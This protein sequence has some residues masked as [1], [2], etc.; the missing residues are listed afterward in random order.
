[1][2]DSKLAVQVRS[3]VN[4]LPSFPLPRPCRV[5]LPVSTLGRMLAMVSYITIMF[6][7]LILVDAPILSQHFLDDVA[8]RAAW[9]TLTQIPLVYL[10]ASKRGPISFFAGI[11]YERIN[12]IH[13]L[14]GPGLLLSATLHMG[15]MKSSISTS[16]ILQSQD[17]NMSVVRYGI[18]AYGVLVWISVT[19]ILPLRNWSY[20]IFYLNHWISTLGFLTIIFQHVPS[21]ACPPIYL[22][23]GIVML[24]KSKGAYDCIRNNFSVRPVNRR[25]SH[26]RRIPS[27][28]MLVTGYPIELTAPSPFILGF[29]TQTKDITTILRISNIPFSWRPGQHIRL[30]IPA[31]GPFEVHSFTPANCSALLPPPLPPRKDIEQHG[32]STHLLAPSASVQ[33]SEMLLM[34]RAYSGLTRRLANHHAD[35]LMRPC[36][37]ATE[38]IPA[39]PL[40]AYIDGPYGSVPRW[41]EYENLVLVATSTG[42]SFI[43]SIM[44]HLEQLCFTGSHIVPTHAI[45]FIWT[46][47]HIDAQLER[48][49]EQLLS[50][51]SAI[52]RDSGI[53]IDAEFF[54]TCLHSSIGLEVTQYDQFAHLRQHSRSRSRS[55]TPPPLS[56]IHPDEIYDEW[57]REAAAEYAKL[58]LT[59]LDPFRTPIDSSE[60]WSFE[61]DE[62]SENDTLVDGHLLEG[63]DDVYRPLLPPP[64]AS[65]QRN[66]A[67]TAEENTC[68]GCECAAIQHQRRKMYPARKGG[69]LVVRN[70]ATRPDITSAVRDAITRDGA[71]RTMVAACAHGEVTRQIQG[72][73]A[74]SNLDF[75]HGRRTR[76]VDIFVEGF[77]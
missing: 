45:R 75:A 23:F 24:D 32:S 38:S 21:Y 34:V 72:L 53:E 71:E 35:W 4:I 20:R 12:W 47:R 48:T 30:Y 55:P 27:R 6:F 74:R 40:I 50:R 62:T 44:D 11:S 16:A 1:M 58:Y 43:L 26:F 67:S 46:T 2:A 25:F 49:V 61:S 77:S 3:I 36:P 10:L 70:Y 15:I 52:L 9:V 54:T 73:V 33:T 51:Y 37:N 19:S 60:R 22:A 68:K 13:R 5:V 28:G 18:S 17:R 66:R 76:G 56:I 7:L 59:Q 65:Q 57:D 69:E 29:P 41:E 14:I 42:V 64:A 63:H 8:F 31:L 39:S